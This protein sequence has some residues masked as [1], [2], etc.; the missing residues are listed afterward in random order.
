[1]LNSK[2]FFPSNKGAETIKA[3]ADAY[4]INYVSLVRHISNHIAVN[5]DELAEMEMD[6]IAKRSEAQVEVLQYQ[7]GQ[8]ATDVW[9][10]VMEKAR[11]GLEDGSIKLTANHLLKAAK[12]K[13]DF[14]IKKKN[15]DM[16]IQEM[17]WH[18]ASGEALGSTKYDKRIIQGEEAESYNPTEIFAGLASEGE[19]RPSDLHSGTTGDAPAPR[20]DKVLEGDDF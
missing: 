6:R 4:K 15:Q 5:V 3:I 7:E 10:D 13:S 19:T 11:V 17:M 8:K 18:F 20:T 9:N 14:E 12:D 1:V 16:A 2:K